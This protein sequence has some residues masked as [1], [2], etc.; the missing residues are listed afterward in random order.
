MRASHELREIRPALGSKIGRGR[1]QQRCD[2]IWSRTAACEH[3][4]SIPRGSIAPLRSRG[5]HPPSWRW[6]QRLLFRVLSGVSPFRL[7][8]CSDAKRR[9]EDDDPKE[10][11]KEKEKEKDRAAPAPE[12]G[13]RRKIEY[14]EPLPAAAPSDAS[15]GG[16]D[17]SRDARGGGGGGTSRGDPMEEEKPSRGG[18]GRDTDRRGGGGGGGGG[19]QGGGRDKERGRPRR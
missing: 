13:K 12:E 17:R 16:R 11:E 15:R 18:G 10:K 4:I 9:R 19:E 2:V 3:N 6:I 7:V 5:A 14:T 8:V 1:Q